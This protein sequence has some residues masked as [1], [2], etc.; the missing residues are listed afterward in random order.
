[1]YRLVIAVALASSLS[2]V[3]S[4]D[5]LA[6]GGRGGG[7][8]GG[9]HVGH[10]FHFSGNF[11]GKFQGGGNRAA[12]LGGIRGGSA[13]GFRPF[14][15]SLARAHILNRHLAHHRRFQEKIIIFGGY[16]ANCYPVWNGYAWISSCGL[17]YDY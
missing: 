9:A 5:A 14:P 15:N 8:G 6:R 10:G 3:S 13:T 2:I 12:S 7:V 1:M 4:S 17:G 16:G 11:A